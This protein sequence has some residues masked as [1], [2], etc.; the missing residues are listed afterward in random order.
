LPDDFLVVVRTI[1]SASGSARFQAGKPG[2]DLPQ[3][4][5]DA[6]L[7]TPQG[8]QVLKNQIV[9]VVAHGQASLQGKG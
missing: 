9:D 7:S 3:L 1:A 8:A 5:F 6:V 4:A 2:G